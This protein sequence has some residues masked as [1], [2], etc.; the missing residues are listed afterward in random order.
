MIDYAKSSYEISP[1]ISY[2]EIEWINFLKTAKKL[3]EIS[4]G[5]GDIL[6]II[7]SNTLLIFPLLAL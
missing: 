5:N 6:D 4:D 7:S 1:T 2:G 3:S